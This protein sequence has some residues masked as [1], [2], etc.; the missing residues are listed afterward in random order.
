MPIMVSIGFYLNMCIQALKT[1]G[2]LTAIF[3]LND[4]VVIRTHIYVEE[5]GLVSHFSFML[6]AYT[7]INTKSPNEI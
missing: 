1:C 4:K 3:S 5:K 7:F 6:K 2:A